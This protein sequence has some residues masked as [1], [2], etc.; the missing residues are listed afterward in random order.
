MVAPAFSA[1]SRRGLHRRAVG[2]GIGEGH[3]QLDH[4]GAGAGQLFQNGEAGF[5]VR[6]AGGDEGHEGGA[7]FLLQAREACQRAGSQFFSQRG[8]DG[9]DILV[10]AARQ[11]DGDDLVLASSGGATL[12]T[13]AMACADSSAGMMPS[14]LE[15]SMKASSASWSVMEK[16]FTRPISFSQECSGPTPG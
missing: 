15:S 12:A 9:E 7:A 6:I 4:V 16:Y 13:W 11:A 5:H 2:H 14:S 10:A 1:R 3:A 8:G